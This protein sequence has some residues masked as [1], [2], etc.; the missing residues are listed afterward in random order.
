MSEAVAEA[1]GID[2]N[3]AQEDEEMMDVEG[4]NSSNFNEDD[5]DMINEIIDSEKKPIQF[6]IV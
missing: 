6:K 5:I 4:A 2:D 1:V 3:E